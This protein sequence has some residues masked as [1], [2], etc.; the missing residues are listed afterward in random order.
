MRSSRSRLHESPSW[1]SNKPK[2]ISVCKLQKKQC[3]WIQSQVRR[4]FGSRLCSLGSCKRRG[5][6]KFAFFACFRYAISLAIPCNAFLLFQQQMTEK[7]V[8][9]L[10]KL[11]WEISPLLAIYLPERLYTTEAMVQQL[12][13]LV[14]SN[15]DV[16]A[17]HQWGL[18]GCCWKLSKGSLRPLL[19]LLRLWVTFP[20][21]VLSSRSFTF[22]NLVLWRAASVE[23]LGWSMIRTWGFQSAVCF[24]SCN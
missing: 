7:Q 21:G 11:A 19:R 12:T 8:K 20:A 9:D 3:C 4:R 13:R 10:V 23:Y 17:H 24:N 22:V 5:G 18:D 14:M 15:P 16:S 2:A 6:T 1:F